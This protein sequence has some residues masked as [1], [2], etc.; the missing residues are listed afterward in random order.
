MGQCIAPPKVALFDPYRIDT[1]QPIAKKLIQVITSS[2]TPTAMLNLGPWGFGTKYRV[3]YNLIFLFMPFIENS[4]T[5]LTGLRIF[6]H[7]GSNDADSRKYVLFL[8]FV[9]IAPHL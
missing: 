1:P 6:A 3:K 5:G 8:G 7:D 4:P 9:D 2:I